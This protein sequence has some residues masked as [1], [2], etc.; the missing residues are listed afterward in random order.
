MRCVWEQ[1]LIEA[2]WPF[3]SP[4]CG[5]S[6]GGASVVWVVFREPG[7][8]DAPVT[9]AEASRL[10]KESGFLFFVLLVDLEGGFGKSMFSFQEPA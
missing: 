2:S 1:Y 9:A 3:Q 6:G 5:R 7:V 10:R 8:S 4:T